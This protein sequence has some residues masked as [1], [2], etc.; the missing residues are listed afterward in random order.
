MVQRRTVEAGGHDR[1]SSTS[2]QNP[3]LRKP[4]AHAARPEESRRRHGLLHRRRAPSRRARA[5]GASPS[6]SVVGG[7]I[8]CA[9]NRSGQSWQHRA[10]AFACAPQRDGH[11]PRRRR[12]AIRRRSWVARRKLPD[13]GHRCGRRARGWCMVAVCAAH[14]GSGSGGTARRCG[15]GRDHAW[16]RI[17][18]RRPDRRRVCSAGLHDEPRYDAGPG[19][20]KRHAGASPSND[21]ANAGP[22]QGSRQ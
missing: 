5:R 6:I 1:A 12:Y 11:T 16:S 9:R 8:G 20:A 7:G 13:R 2:A 15:R 4:R 21:A 14:R 22:S 10:G 17:A 18:R 3:R 19:L